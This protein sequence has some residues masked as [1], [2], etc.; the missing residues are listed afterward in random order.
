MNLWNSF[1][2]GLRE[3]LSHKF[4]SVL[5]MMGIILGV[6]SLLTTFALVEDSRRK[7]VRC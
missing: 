3:I 7:A 2:T 1:Y 5:T 6:A 4:R